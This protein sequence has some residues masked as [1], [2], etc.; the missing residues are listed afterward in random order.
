MIKLKDILKESYV[1]ERKFGEPLLTL[2]DVQKKKN[3]EKLNEKT[4]KRG[5]EVIKHITGGKTSR[6]GN[7]TKSNWI[8]H[9]DTGL[10]FG[11]GGK[12]KNGIFVTQIFST[13]KDKYRVEFFKSMA[14]DFGLSQQ[15]KGKQK[16]MKVV[17][18]V[19]G[20]MLYSTLKTYLGI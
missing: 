19:Q 15:G 3:E 10:I 20:Q 17:K 7:M 2:A 4:T 9:H 6:F 12:W 11:G 16:P 8:Q 18:N 5:F 1:W 14:D 13:G